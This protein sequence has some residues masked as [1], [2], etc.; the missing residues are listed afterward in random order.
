MVTKLAPLKF[1]SLLMGVWFLATRS[2]RSLAGL[3]ASLTDRIE[4]GHY[5]HLLG[6]QA[7]FFLIFVITR[8]LAALLLLAV[9]PGCRDRCRGA[10]Y[11][12]LREHSW[13]CCCAC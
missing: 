3:I 12:A 11:E 6:G 13:R 5:F 1:A 10:M 9:G 8:S 2:R 4:R 7:D